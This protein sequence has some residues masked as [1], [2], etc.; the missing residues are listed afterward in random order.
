MNR[1]RLDS[2]IEFFSGTLFND[3]NH[4][5]RGRD[6]QRTSEACTLDDVRGGAVLVALCRGVRTHADSADALRTQ[7]LLEDSVAEQVASARDSR[8]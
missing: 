5:T 7:L 3:A 4:R 1:H 6:S 8:S 2:R